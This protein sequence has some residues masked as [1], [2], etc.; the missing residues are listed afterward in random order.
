MDTE[1][2]I[3]AY[4][5][6]M[7]KYP[8]LFTN[9]ESAPECFIVKDK[10][11]LI[12]GQEI[13]YEKQRREGL[14]E[15][16]VDIGIITQD[17]WVVVLRDLVQPAP[18]E[19]RGYIRLLNRSSAVERNGED[20]VV[21]PYQNGRILLIERF[22]HEDR[23]WHWELPRGFGETGQS[24]EQSARRELIEETGLEAV[25][26]VPLW[27]GRYGAVSISY[28]FIYAQGM[29][30]ASSESRSFRWISKE[31]MSEMIRSGEIDD[32]YTIQAYIFASLNALL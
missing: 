22:R 10:D 20:V 21:I 28:F 13:L 24:S 9:D 7:E 30:K 3:V 8:H 5:D 16:T 31:H 14:S 25:R 11:T 17:H 12:R 15:S 27:S 23:I 6:F 29:A 18:G 26:L 2:R 19:Y 4:L 32:P 1:S